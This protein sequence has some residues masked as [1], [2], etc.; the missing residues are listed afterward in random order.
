MTALGKDDM[1]MWEDILN[2]KITYVCWVCGSEI[3]WEVNFKIKNFQKAFI[4]YMG[5]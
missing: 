4:L 2:F 3:L 1:K 5:L